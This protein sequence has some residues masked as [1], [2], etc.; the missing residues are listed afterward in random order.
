MNDIG[1]AVDLIQDIQKESPKEVSK[2]VI[3]E[4]SKDKPKTSLVR[5]C[6]IFSLI[7]I[8]ILMWSYTIYL[9]MLCCFNWSNKIYKTALSSIVASSIVTIIAIII[10]IVLSKLRR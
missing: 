7:F 4:V 3:I 1:T 10:V 6:I 8:V 9:W 2:D 5:D